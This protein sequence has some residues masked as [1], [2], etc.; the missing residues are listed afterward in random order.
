MK[1]LILGAGGMA[2]SMIAR[3]LSDKQHDV[4]CFFRKDFD[5]LNDEIPDLS[6]YDYVI[7]C[8]GL[9]K[10]R[11]IVDDNLFFVVNSKF[12]HNLATKCKRLIHIS[13]DC[14][15]SGHLPEDQSYSNN[16]PKDAQ[17]SYG[18]SK[19]DGEPVKHAMVLR[20]S[21]IGPSKDSNGLFEWFRNTKEPQLRG[22][23]NHW[24]S[25]VTTLE[26][27]KT[28]HHIITGSLYST[29]LFQVASQ[30]VSKYYLLCLINDAFGLSKNIA[31]HQD[32]QAINRSLVPDI[33][34]PH[35]EAQIRELA[36]YLK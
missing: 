36:D 27:A 7:N 18:K 20:T 24:W 11:T 31:A 6:A 9:I 29:G 3:Y 34:A 23:T 32:G 21:I 30:K 22:F 12:P 10:Q 33:Q 4:T 19:A 25:G 8:I 2:G 16:A 1:I 26:L 17:D 35:L 14:V 28:I 15:F 13:S 5:V